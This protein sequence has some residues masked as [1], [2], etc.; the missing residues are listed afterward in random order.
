MINSMAELS[1]EVKI[2][3]LVN[4]IPAFI[5]A[6]L[7][8]VIPETYAQITEAAMYN[9]INLRQ[10]GASILV[11]GIGSVLAIK[12]NDLEKAK[13]LWEISIIW[14]ILMSIIGIWGAFAIPG[15]ATA[16]VGTWIANAILIVLAVL[17]IYVF[18]RETM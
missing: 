9:P 7:F 17:N 1:K 2:I 5:Y 14:L 11:L 3:L 15:T 16:Q 13:I 12:R 8:L 6:F 4:A 18:Y 10:I